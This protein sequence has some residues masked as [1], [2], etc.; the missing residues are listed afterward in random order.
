MKY[1]NKYNDIMAKYKSGEY[2]G[3][4]L[5]MYDILDKANSH[6][7]IDRLDLSEIQGLLDSASGITKKMFSML[8]QEIKSKVML[9]DSLEKELK[10]YDID[11]YRDSGDGSDEALANNLKLV[12]KYCSDDELPEDTE[13]ML[14]PVEDAAHLGVIKIQ[15][16]CATTSFSFRHE[17]IHYFRDVKVGNRVTVE[18]A[19]KIKGKTPNDEEQEVNYLTAASIMPLEE[20]SA[21]LDE[22]ESVVSQEAEKVFLSDLAKKYEQDEDAVLRR[23]VEVRCLVDYMQSA[24]K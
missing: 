17:I 9:M 1:L 16:D 2:G 4:N 11:S 24:K 15:K 13:A 8:K 23:I 14:C 6:D 20:I 10:K 12:V 3:E 22:F 18:L 19:R 5:S 21:K 7:L